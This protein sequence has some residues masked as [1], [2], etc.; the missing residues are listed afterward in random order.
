MIFSVKVE[1][2]LLEKSETKKRR[3]TLQLKESNN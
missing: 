2:I 1:S 3:N